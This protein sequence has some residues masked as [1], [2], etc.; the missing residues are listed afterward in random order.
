MSR[1]PQVTQAF[2]DAFNT[3]HAFHQAGQLDIVAARAWF[4]VNVPGISISAT[5]AHKMNW[6]KALDAKSIIWH[7]KG[8]LKTASRN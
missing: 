8:A 5:P 3:G 2:P 7:Y 6:S 1:P 4:H